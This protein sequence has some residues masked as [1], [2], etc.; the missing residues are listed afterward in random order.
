MAIDNNVAE[1]ELKKIAVG[2]KNWLTIGAPQAGTTAAIHFSITSSCQRLQVE[3][4]AYLQD[5][6]TRWPTMPVEQRPQLLPERWQASRRSSQ[7]SAPASAP[8]TKSSSV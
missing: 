5:V 6:L 7:G 1:R 2:R 3:P 8:E 4:W